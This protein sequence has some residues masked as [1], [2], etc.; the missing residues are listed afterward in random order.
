MVLVA[1]ISFAQDIYCAGKVKNIFITTGGNVHVMGDWATDRW[2][3]ICNLNDADVVTCSM[4]TSL[5]STAAKDDL[6]VIINYKN[7]AHTCNTLPKYDEAPKPS[8]IMLKNG[9]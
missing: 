4:W 1:S 9:I 6:N 3:K 8:Y 2:A 5:I 7:T